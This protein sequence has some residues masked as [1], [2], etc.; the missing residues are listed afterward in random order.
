MNNIYD[1]PYYKEV[2]EAQ[3]IKKIQSYFKGILETELEKLGKNQYLLIADE[4]GIAQAEQDFE[5]IPDLENE[6]L[7]ERRKR[8]I[9]RNSTKPPYTFRYLK[10]RLDEIF[11]TGNYE[12][13][14]DIAARSIS[15]ETAVENAFLFTEISLMINKLKPAN[16]IYLNS[17]FLVHEI[18]VAEEIWTAR[19]VYNYRLGTTWILGQSPFFSEANEEIVKMANEQSITAEYLNKIAVNS[20]NE[21]VAVRLNNSVILSSLQKTAEGNIGLITYTVQNT[22]VPEITKI[23]LLGETNKILASANIYVPVGEEVKIKHKIL[24][25]EAK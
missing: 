25:R 1:S 3:E 24:I 14:R 18:G 19:L 4:V 12:F 21:V 10:S 16:M 15:V 13:K 17:P 6:D 7:E 2:L 9:L 23:E 22:Q 20:I 5:I 8:V 11:G